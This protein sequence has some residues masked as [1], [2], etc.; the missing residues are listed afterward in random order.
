[1]STL[2]NLQIPQQSDG[3]DHP[4][5]VALARS[6]ELTSREIEVLMAMSEGESSPV[7]AG[8]LGISERTVKFHISNIRRKLGDPT[9]SQLSIIAFLIQATPVRIAAVQNCS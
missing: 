8:L 7:L 1:M 4:V 5:S 9:R 2:L 3:S 6:V